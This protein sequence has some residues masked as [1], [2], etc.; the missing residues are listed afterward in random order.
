M[1]AL[2]KPGWAVQI[3]D[4]RQ[5]VSDQWVVDGQLHAVDYLEVS[6]RGLRQFHTL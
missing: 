1:A 3:M 6:T 4:N 2:S 5:F